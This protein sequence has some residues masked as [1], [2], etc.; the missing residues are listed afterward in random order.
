N[1]SSKL[2]AK[3]ESLDYSSKGQIQSN[4]KREDTGGLGKMNR[5]LEKPGDPKTIEDGPNDPFGLDLT[6]M[7][8][9]LKTARHRDR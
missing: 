7:P 5:P 6:K 9:Q 2:A 8:T 4:N 1:P 3:A